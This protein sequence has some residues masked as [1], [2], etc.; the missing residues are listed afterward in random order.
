VSEGILDGYDDEDG[1]EMRA[2]QLA[3]AATLACAIGAPANTLAE[4]ITMVQQ[5]TPRPTRLPIEGDLPSL[6]GATG[7]LNSPPLTPVD[8]RGKVVIADREFEIEFLDPGVELLAF[9]FG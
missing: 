7:W 9:T 1:V 3:L 8:L 5:A 2:H 4:D 6:D